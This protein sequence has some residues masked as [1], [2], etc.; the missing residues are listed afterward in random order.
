MSYTEFTFDEIRLRSGGAEI[1]ASVEVRRGRSG[2]IFRISRGEF[3]RNGLELGFRAT[4]T[5]DRAGGAV[6]MLFIRRL[7]GP[8]VPRMRELK[9]FIR[10]R[11][12]AGQ[13]GIG[14]ALF[15]EDIRYP[16][17]LLTI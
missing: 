4:D 8:V 13:S 15:L 1:P 2:E 9:D 7:S 17:P 10:I 11:A 12:E 6:P 5:G 3:I 16:Y 14:E